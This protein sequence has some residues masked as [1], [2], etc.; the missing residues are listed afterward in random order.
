MRLRAI[1]RHLGWGQPTVHNTH[2]PPAGR[3][4]PPDA[5]PV[6]ATSTG[7]SPTC[8][9]ASTTPTACSLSRTCARN[10]PRGAPSSLQQPARLG[11][12]PLGVARCTASAAAAP[13]VRS[14]VGWITRHPD[15]LTEDE[16]TQLKPVLDDCP[17]LDQTH[18]PVPAFTQ[19]FAR[20][21]GADL[22][23]WI[24]TAR[25]TQLPGVTGFA[26]EL[27]TDLEAV[28]AGL[29]GAS[30]PTTTLSNWR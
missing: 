1:A 30:G 20:R 2:G 19:M 22:P 21:T 18:Q 12:Q 29:T 5:E 17:E 9:G 28:I 26:H 23:D 14:L 4:W 13:S 11:S 16:T 8:N 27:T 15:A 7:T 6:P 25:A 3:T 24:S 10:S